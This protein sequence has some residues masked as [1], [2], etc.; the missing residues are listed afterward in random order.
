MRGFLSEDCDHRAGD[1]ETDD[2][3]DVEIAGVIGAS[4]RGG[5]WFDAGT[6]KVF[7]PFSVLRAREHDH[8]SAAATIA[9]P[10]WWARKE[11]LI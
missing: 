11:G 1:V 5:F 4:A 6:K 2:R 3:R 8:A 7:V 9:V 10:A